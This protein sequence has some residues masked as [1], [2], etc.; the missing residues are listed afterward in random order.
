MKIEV[1]YEAQ[2]RQ[3]AGAPSMHF[4]MAEDST[5]L[6]VLRRAA[7]EGGSEFG[8]KLLSTEGGLQPGILVFIGEQ[9]VA[10]DAVPQQSVQDGDSILLLP[11]IS[12]G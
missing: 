8:A 3:L 7:E 12:G 11:P 5:L 10:A 9:A 1:L 2:L 4:E 6:D